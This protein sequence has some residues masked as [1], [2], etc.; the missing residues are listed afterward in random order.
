MSRAALA[1]TLR[2]VLAPALMLLGY[3]LIQLS[4]RTGE[5]IEEIGGAIWF[6]L[7]VLILVGPWTF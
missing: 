3:L 1:L 5:R 2:F 7:G 4:K 6:G